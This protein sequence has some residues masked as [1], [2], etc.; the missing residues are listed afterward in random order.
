[1]VNEHTWV[2]GECDHPPLLVE[3]PRPYL[4][5]DSAA[6]EALRKVVFDPKVLKNF[7]FYKNFR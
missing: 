2:G 4:E 6:A 3:E 5:P 7:E 1:M